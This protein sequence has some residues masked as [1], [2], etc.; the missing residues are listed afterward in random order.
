[1]HGQAHPAYYCTLDHYIYCNKLLEIPVYCLYCVDMCS[2]ARMHQLF[3][4]G[5]VL[6]STDVI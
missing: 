5:Q 4:T 1:L 3:Y 2:A 6:C